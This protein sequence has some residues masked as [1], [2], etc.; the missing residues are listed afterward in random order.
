MGPTSVSALEDA[1]ATAASGTR[2][3]AWSVTVIVA[4]ARARPFAGTWSLSRLTATVAGGPIGPI[5]PGGAPV[6]EFAAP[7]QGTRLVPPPPPPAPA[8]T[9]PPPPP[10]PSAPPPPPPPPAVKLVVAPPSP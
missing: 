9:Q 2:R 5:V 6:A 10:P 7:P 1:S 3:P 4:V 8:L